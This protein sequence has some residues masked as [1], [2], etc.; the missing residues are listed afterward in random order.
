[1]DHND[2]SEKFYNEADTSTT[3]RQMRKA[4]RANIKRKFPDDSTELVNEKTDTLMVYN[5]LSFDNFNIL[6]TVERLISERLND[7]SIDDNS[8]KN[9]KT[10]DGIFAEAVA[11]CHKA[12]GYDYLYRT[13]KEMYG[14]PRAKRL[15]ANMLDYSLGLSDSTNIL[16]VYCY[17]LDASRLVIEGRD[18]GQLPSGP[19][20]R[21]SSYISAL[22][23]TVHQLS[24]H[25]AG[26]I[27]I[28]TF[29]FDVTHLSLYNMGLKLDNLSDPKCRKHYEN[30]FQQFVHSVNH[31]SRK[32]SESPFTN[33]SIFDHVKIRNFVSNDLSW[34][35]PVPDWWDKEESEWREYVVA[36]IY[37]LQNVFLDFFDKGDPLNNG[38]PYRF[39]VFTENFSK[40]MGE[41]GWKIMDE[42]F[43]D[44]IV[45]RDISR[46][47]LFN[48]EGSKVCS[49]CRMINDNEMLEL[50]SQSNSFGAG[51]L[52]SLGSH[53]VVTPNY[54]RMA[55]EAESIEHFWELVEERLDDSKDILVA[56]KKLIKKLADNGLQ[57]FIQNGW[58]AMPRLFSTF[59]IM[60]L[61]ECEK[62]LK[63]KFTIE[64]DII[65]EV[66]IY[67]NKKAKEYTLSIPECSFNIEQIPGESYAVRLA[68]TDKTLYG[69][70]AVPYELYA[71]QFVPLWEDASIWDK[72]DVDGKYNSL[73][74][75][76][77]IVHA[78]IGEKVTPTQAKEIIRY[79]TRVG[80]E[81]FALNAIYSQCENKHTS[82][83]DVN[84]C[85]VCGGAIKEKLTRVVGFFT[86][87]SSWN[88]TRRE[89][90]FEKRTKVK[91]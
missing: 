69:E 10:V 70:E 83:G 25:L 55:L 29:F 66:L 71:N 33:L 37:E 27:A 13:M 81:H 76:G 5:G 60:G 40:E 36:Y 15:M 12:V 80:C 46:Y 16:K 14:K 58:I 74:T 35:F 49:C 6:K 82:F 78:T 50:A 65:S 38:L 57:L 52:A 63:S 61:Y 32:G 22:C 18:F 45:H 59:G 48:S 31:L 34:Y 86:P 84:A 44:N 47:N 62:T 85:P 54:N 41:N 8:N 87:V 72:L 89:W 26:A 53:R 79:A 19:C 30:E 7:V 75:G 42:E 28:G 77:G 64:S 88:K 2:F 3:I 17:A 39:P 73:I 20:K 4:L 1:M 51:A 21:V 68:H 23:E 24:S 91:M 11:P 9:E 56:H 90:E 43:L 67:I